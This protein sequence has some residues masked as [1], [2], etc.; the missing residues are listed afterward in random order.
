MPPSPKDSANPSESHLA[1]SD[2]LDPPG[3]SNHEILPGKRTEVGSHSLLQGIFPTQG[4]NHSLPHCRQV[5]YHLSHQGSRS[6]S[7]S[8]SLLTPFYSP[9]SLPTASEGHRHTRGPCTIAAVAMGTSG[10]TVGLGP[11]SVHWER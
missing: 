9:T 10:K 2:P 7:R 8:S 4:S 5:L 6:S 3:S 11:G 1:M